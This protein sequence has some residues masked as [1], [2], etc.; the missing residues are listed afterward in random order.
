MVKVAGHVHGMDAAMYPVPGN[1]M[2]TEC[3]T[4]QG[5]TE[6]DLGHHPREGPQLRWIEL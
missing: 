2:K 3:E 1:R 4:R 5:M 6:N